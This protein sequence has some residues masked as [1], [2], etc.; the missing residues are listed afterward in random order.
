VRVI[1]IELREGTA[2]PRKAGTEQARGVSLPLD[3]AY[4]VAFALQN[5]CGSPSTL[6]DTTCFVR[7][8][9]YLGR[10]HV[11]LLDRRPP[12]GDDRVE[13]RVSGV[14]GSV[15]LRMRT[16]WTPTQRGAQSILGTAD[17]DR[18][19]VVSAPPLQY[20]NLLR[21]AGIRGRV[22][23]RATMDTTGRAEPASV[24]V[25]ESPH[26]G[27]DQAARDFVLQARVLPRRV[28]GRAVRAEM[29]LP[30]SFSMGE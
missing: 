2:I 20:P 8:Y 13:V 15:L 30:I 18:P 11:M 24:R 19:V 7:G 26:P 29:T 16:T 28:H 27:F 1:W 12:A 25:I 10:E 6:R 3:S 5:L 14:A 4:A 17:L 21:Q 23:V 9:Q 22:R